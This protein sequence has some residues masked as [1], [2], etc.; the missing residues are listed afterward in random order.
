MNFALTLENTSYVAEI[1]QC[2]DGIPLAIELAAAHVNTLSTEQIAARLN[3]NFNILTSRGRLPLP[4]H[5]TLP[6]SMDWSWDLLSDSEC[7][8]LRRLSVFAGGWTLEAAEAVC[9]VEEI[10]SDRMLD[11]LSH[12]VN[13]SL[14]VVEHTAEEFRYRLLETVR[15]YARERLV[16]AGEE[17][18]IRTRHLNYFVDLSKQAERALVGPTQVEWMIRLNDELDKPRQASALWHLGW[19]A[20]DKNKFIYW[21]R[22]IALFRTIGDHPALVGRLSSMGNSLLLYGDFESAQKYLDEADT[23]IQEHS[24]VKNILLLCAWTACV[25]SG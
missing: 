8:L 22:A 4:R 14:V 3:E 5:Q 2:L 20:H 16:K 1:C 6:A 7:I 21:K 17:E 9:R 18:N 19:I 23:L 24:G 13:K 11:L 25:D 12:P 10:E 15:R